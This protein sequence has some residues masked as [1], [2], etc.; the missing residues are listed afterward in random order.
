VK[1]KAK[2]VLQNQKGE[3]ASPALKDVLGDL[4]ATVLKPSLGTCSFTGNEDALT[5]KSL[6]EFGVSPSFEKVAS[7]LRR[8]LTAPSS[9]D[10]GICVAGPSE[11]QQ[12]FSLHKDGL[13][14]FLKLI[15]VKKK[16]IAPRRLS[17]AQLG[18]KTVALSATQLGK[19]LYKEIRRQSDK[20]RG[21]SQEGKTK[22]RLMLT[23]FPTVTPVE[24]TLTTSEGER[25]SFPVELDGAR[26]KLQI[27]D[28][29]KWRVSGSSETFAFNRKKQ[30]HLMLLSEL[31]RSGSASI[32]DIRD[33]DYFPTVRPKVSKRSGREYIATLLGSKNALFGESTF[34][35]D[36]VV[37]VS[38]SPGKCA[39]VIQVGSKSQQKV[40]FGPL[41]WDSW[42]RVETV[43]PIQSGEL[44]A[45]KGFLKAPVTNDEEG[46]TAKEFDRLYKRPQRCQSAC[47]SAAPAAAGFRVVDEDGEFVVFDSIKFSYSRCMD[48]C[49]VKKKYLSCLNRVPGATGQKGKYDYLQGCEDR[50]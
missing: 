22:V 21:T 15:K 30:G 10:Q 7:G 27:S 8:A 29:A 50:R 49:M 23:P 31:I 6:V 9:A 14:S 11:Q 34:R 40:K 38:R 12:R 19:D 24:L 44:E 3:N 28:S 33:S 45:K 26:Q 42:R 47:N 1:Q 25:L 43:K 35:V 48:T 41:S 46:L 39:L 17:L 16:R 36:P 5:C 4:S 13:S 37:E 18:K 2:E 20:D 32:T